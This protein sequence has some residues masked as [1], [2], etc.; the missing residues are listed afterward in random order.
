MVPLFH[1]RIFNRRRFF[2]EIHEKER[3]LAMGDG[4]RAGLPGP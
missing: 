4:G 2:D 3:P 1:P